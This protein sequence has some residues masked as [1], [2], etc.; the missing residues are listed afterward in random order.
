M[1]EDELD[2]LKLYVDGLSLVYHEARNARWLVRKGYLDRDDWIWVLNLPNKREEAWRAIQ[3]QR[4]LGREGT[5]VADASRHFE[6]QFA[7][8]LPQLNDL[9]RNVHWRHA[10][11]YGGHAWI[12]IADLV[13]RLGSRLHDEG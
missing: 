1:T 11:G 8:S 3:T 7:K 10:K 9:Y 12:N 13:A 5:S 6:S 2:P 4:Q